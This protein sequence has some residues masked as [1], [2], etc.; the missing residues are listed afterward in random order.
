MNFFFE[1]EEIR[2]EKYKTEKKSKIDK[3]HKTGSFCLTQL[4]FF[5][6][7]KG[8]IAMYRICTT[9]LGIFLKKNLYL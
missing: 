5:F 2:L 1:V 8:Y 9:D 3:N 6:E 4:D 7:T